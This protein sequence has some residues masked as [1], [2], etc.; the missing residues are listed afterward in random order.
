MFSVT[1]GVTQ[2]RVVESLSR[3][4]NANSEIGAECTHMNLFNKLQV[5][6][7]MSYTHLRHLQ[8]ITETE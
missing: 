8:C 7:V 2:V 3:R 5:G 4:I 1:L 6:L